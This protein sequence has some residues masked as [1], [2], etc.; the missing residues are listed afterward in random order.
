MTFAEVIVILDS[1][2]LSG[3]VYSRVADAV[4]YC[5]SK[6]DQETAR[7]IQSREREI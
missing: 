3:K 5:C 2:V 4:M 1:V 6:V 7:E